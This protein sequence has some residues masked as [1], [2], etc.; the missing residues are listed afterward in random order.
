MEDLW[1]SPI[2]QVG[3]Q[4]WIN[5]DKQALSLSALFFLSYFSL[6][7]KRQLPPSLLPPL[8]PSFR[9]FPFDVLTVVNMSDSDGLHPHRDLLIHC[10]L[11]LRFHRPTL[12][13]GNG[14]P[15][16]Q[17]NQTG[18]VPIMDK[19]RQ[20]SFKSKCIIFLI[21]FL[22]MLETPIATISSTTTSAVIP[23]FPF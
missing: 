12:S 2:K 3:F 20:T 18:W 23:V 1:C 8:L 7:W 5:M 17:P 4:S 9:Y 13:L 19:H 21:I 16:V 10:L 15:V 6:C 22:P 11:I 14:G